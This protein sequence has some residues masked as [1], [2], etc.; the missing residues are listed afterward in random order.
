[1]LA[2]TSR[3]TTYGSWLSAPNAITSCDEPPLCTLMTPSSSPYMP[4]GVSA[5]FITDGISMQCSSI[6]FFISK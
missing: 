2:P 5:T 1:M 6:I 3:S 4:S